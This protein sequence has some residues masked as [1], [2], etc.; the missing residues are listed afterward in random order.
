MHE[1]QTLHLLLICALRSPY[2]HPARAHHLS[3]YIKNQNLI[4][5]R[6]IIN[7]FIRTAAQSIS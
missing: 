4:Q 2:A 5:S 1:M 7:P 3:G 6:I